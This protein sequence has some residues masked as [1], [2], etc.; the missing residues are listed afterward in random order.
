MSSFERSPRISDTCFFSS[1]AFYVEI[2]KSA[3]VSN[4]FCQHALVVSLVQIAFVSDKWPS[5]RSFVSIDWCSSLCVHIYH[6]QLPGSGAY[7]ATRQLR[8]SLDDSLK[9]T[10]VGRVRAV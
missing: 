8:V 1:A 4:F 6:F 5:R 10:N 9:M 3:H 7:N 2:L